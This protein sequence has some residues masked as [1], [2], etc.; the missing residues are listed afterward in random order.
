MDKP[1]RNG[2][3][4][5]R[6]EKL[7]RRLDTDGDGMLTMKEFKIG[8]K[9]LHYKEE[10]AWTMRIIRRLFDEC[11]KNRDGLLSI[12][13]FNS[14]ILDNEGPSRYEIARGI[15]QHDD[16]PAFLKNDEHRRQIK[17]QEDKLNLSDDEE[18][19]VFRKHRVLTDHELIRKVGI[20]FIFICML[21]NIYLY[22][23][24]RY[25]MML[26][27]LKMVQNINTQKL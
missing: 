23:L 1:D 15:T 17:S 6:Y 5:P 12:K 10:K 9:K 7:F 14:Y 13:E 27:Q 20:N 2:Y 22:R 24:M 26:Y 16:R 3:V 21:S 11:D 4:M 18:D 8:L 25:F 19:E